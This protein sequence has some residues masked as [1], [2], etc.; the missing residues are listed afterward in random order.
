MNLRAM[1][2]NVNVKVHILFVLFVLLQGT[3]FPALVALANS[4]CALSSAYL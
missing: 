3:P 2:Y 4:L 1:Q